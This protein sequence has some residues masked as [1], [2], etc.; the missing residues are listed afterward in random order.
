MQMQKVK[1]ILLGLITLLIVWLFL[2][3]NFHLYLSTLSLKTGEYKVNDL[4]S[5]SI[6]FVFPDTLD[7]L[8]II[9]ETNNPTVYSLVLKLSEYYGLG[10]SQTIQLGKGS[11]YLKLEFHEPT[12]PSADLNSAGKFISNFQ[13]PNEKFK[14]GYLGHID[15]LPNVS[16]I[17]TTNSIYKFIPTIDK[18]NPSQI[19]LDEIQSYNSNSHIRTFFVSIISEKESPVHLPFHNEQARDTF[20][21]K[22]GSLLKNKIRL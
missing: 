18:T 1:F 8:K 3:T 12:Y 15:D 17:L 20:L 4:A 11:K 14:Y 10:I 6:E 7:N 9:I 21:F 2:P 22:L 19:N 5:D 16:F 13:K